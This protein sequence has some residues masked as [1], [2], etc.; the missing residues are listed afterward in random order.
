MTRSFGRVTVWRH[1]RYRWN[2][3]T[4][5]ATGVGFSHANSFLGSVTSRRTL[6]DE[7]KTFSGNDK[8][9]GVGSTGSVPGNRSLSTH[10]AQLKR[11]SGES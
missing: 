8:V 9:Q 3:E 4:A 5:F 7:L 6:D 11:P 2:G 10:R 1:T